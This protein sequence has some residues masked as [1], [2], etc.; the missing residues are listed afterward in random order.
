MT[1]SLNVEGF[2][3]MNDAGIKLTL[4]NPEDILTSPNNVMIFME[5]NTEQPYYFLFTQFR[6]KDSELYDEMVSFSSRMYP[7]SKIYGTQD[8]NLNSSVIDTS[9]PI[10]STF[11]LFDDETIKTE[12]PVVIGQTSVYWSEVQLDEKE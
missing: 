10:I 3:M 9:L 5:N 8:L 11:T 1:E 2:N 4:T 7:N 12:N 6:N